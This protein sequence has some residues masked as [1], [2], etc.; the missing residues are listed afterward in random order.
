MP[1]TELEE[2]GRVLIEWARDEAIRNCDR[3]LQGGGTDPVTKRWRTAI[4]T[5]NPEEALRVAI[6]DIVD[7][8][9]ANLLRG[10]DQEA[11]RF[12]F[13]A[14]NGATVD[15]PRDGLGELCGW[16][17]QLTNRCSQQPPSLPFRPSAITLH[18]RF[19]PRFT[20][21]AVAELWR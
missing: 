7:A 4:A 19:R 21:A 14:S 15:L 5:G 2:L 9:I 18:R 8:T 16:F 6:P 3:H 20:P 13:T 17:K 1:R 12:A 10:I 11:L